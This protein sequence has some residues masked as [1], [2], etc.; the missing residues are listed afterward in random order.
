MKKTKVHQRPTVK[1]LPGKGSD[2]G[3]I[4]KAMTAAGSFKKPVHQPA[5][6]TPLKDTLT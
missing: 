6:W 5:K 4:A 2:T 1:T 3:L